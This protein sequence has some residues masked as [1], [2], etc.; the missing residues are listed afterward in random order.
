EADDGIVGPRARGDTRAIEADGLLERP[1]R[2]LDDAALDLIDD[3]VGVD[4]LAG[5]DGRDRARHPHASGRAI[6]D[7]VGDDG[8]ITRE[9]L[10]A[11]E[12]NTTS[13]GALAPGLRRPPGALS[14]GF[15]DCTT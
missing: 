15:D 11:R 2:G 14:G 3:A 1:A 6:D 13:A 5:V 10:V 12:R 8:A 4:D 9:V 7:H